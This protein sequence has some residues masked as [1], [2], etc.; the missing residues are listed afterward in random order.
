MNHLELP[1]AQLC[2]PGESLQSFVCHGHPTKIIV[3]DMGEFAN[4]Q[5]TQ[6]NP[7]DYWIAIELKFEAKD[8]FNKI[9]DKLCCMLELKNGSVLLATQKGLIGTIDPQV[10]L[11]NWNGLM[12][13]RLNDSL[14]EQYGLYENGLKTLIDMCLV[15][16]ENPTQL[17]FL[18]KTLKKNN[19][20]N[21]NEIEYYYEYR[22]EFW[23]LDEINKQI[24][25]TQIDQVPSR[26]AVHN[27][28]S[29]SYIFDPRV[30]IKD[31]IDK[32]DESKCNPV[33]LYY[34]K[35][36]KLFIILDEQTN[37]VFWISSEKFNA[38]KCIQCEDLKKPSG[39]VISSNCTSYIVNQEGLLVINKDGI[40]VKHKLESIPNDI[41]YCET[42][43]SI[44]F[45]DNNALYKSKLNST[46][47]NSI[48]NQ[49]QRY[50][51]LFSSKNNNKLFKRVL[52]C[53]DF[54]FILDSSSNVLMALEKKNLKF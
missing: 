37:C 48:N 39:L 51:R 54:V 31:Y 38:K 23:L 1:H 29:G 33:R 32:I 9:E 50:K 53:R 2:T 11:T 26:I 19:D 12:R 30:T 42:D 24:C 47:N 8:D 41:S 43:N 10:S 34:D 52:H 21:N 28:L 49:Q 36:N 17:A 40:A 3:D 15:N 14:D 7:K 45:I 13:K 44:Y 35:L 4:E 46:D 18:T 22:V 20:F 25:L 27:S 16:T 5:N 6:T